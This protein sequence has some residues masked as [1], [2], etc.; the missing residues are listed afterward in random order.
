LLAQEA[1]GKSRGKWCD[2]GGKCDRGETIH[3]AAA[4]EAYEESRR[5]VDLTL[6][7]VAK[8]PNILFKK[9][10]V[11]YTMFLSSYK[12]KGITDKFRQALDKHET[13]RAFREKADVMWVNLQDIREAVTNRKKLVCKGTEVVLRGSFVK[14]LQYAFEENLL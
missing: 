7:Q 3:E 4:R 5:T 12:E 2:F 8:L 10:H 9:K 11:E 14:L 1:G 13:R 6:E